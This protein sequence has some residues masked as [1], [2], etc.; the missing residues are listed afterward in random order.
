[1]II[2]MQGQAMLFLSTVLVGAG[3]GLFY[4]VF[5]IFRKTAPHSALAVQLEDL[6]FWLAVTVGTFYFMLMQSYGEIRLFSVIGVII[7]AV[8]YLAAVSRFV[9]KGAVVAVNFLKKVIFSALRII[10]LPVRFVFAWLSS[11]FAPPAKK[12]LHKRKRDLRGLVRYGK[13]QMK[14]TSRNLS[15]LRKKV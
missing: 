11:L 5:R 9:V 15:I 10:F 12:F 2:D 1:M 13:I 3:I 6:F 14:K 8:L 4:D 7:G